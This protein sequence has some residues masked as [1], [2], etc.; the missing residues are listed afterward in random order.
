MA[1]IKLMVEGGKMTPG[2]A[3]AQQ[4][5]PMGVNMGK[6]ISDVN[7]ATKE[8]AGVTLP[9]HLTVNADTKEVSIKVLSPPTS[10]LIKKELGVK[11]ASGARL[12]QRVGNFAIE[13]VIGVAKAKHD[14]MLSN[15]FISSVKSVLGTCQAL[16]VLVESKEVREVLDE[17]NDS[18][19]AEEI[20]AQKTDVSDEKK[21]DL[22]EYF[23]TIEAQQEAVKKAEDA[24]AAEKA[25][26]EETKD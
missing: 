18:K 21:A 15:E 23:A 24:E 12:K 7:E 5:G 3:V 2:P 13:Q 11:T 16:G 9:V 19:Y 22:K 8:F 10:E 1:V 25:A 20:S 6:V 4:L 26:K 14:A 17:I